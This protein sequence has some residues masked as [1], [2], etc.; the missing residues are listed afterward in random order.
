MAVIDFTPIIDQVVF[1]ILAAVVTPFVTWAVWKVGQLTHITIQQAQAQVIENALVNG[2]NFAL[3][4][5]Q[6]F[7]DQHGTLPTKSDVIAEATN[8]VVPKVPGALKTLGITPAGVAQRIEARLPKE[9]V[10]ALPPNS[11]P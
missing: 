1:P 5:A 11:A 4:R 9:V 6:A 8:Y 10:S 2:I 3:S 7:A